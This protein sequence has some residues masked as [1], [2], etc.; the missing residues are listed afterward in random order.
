MPPT[1]AEAF[2][3]SEYAHAAK[4][5][6]HMRLKCAASL[7]ELLE[8]D[9]TLTTGERV[10]A[11]AKVQAY[12]PAEDVP[13]VVCWAVVHR[14]APG[15]ILTTPRVELGCVKKA[16]AEDLAAAIYTYER[17]YAERKKWLVDNYTVDKRT[18]DPA[19]IV[20][21]DLTGAEYVK[22]HEARF[23]AFR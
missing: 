21:E 15:G 19:W 6:L 9:T 17:A 22:L 5:P 8:S 12:L 7:L 11:S 10:R 4:L 3:P 2:M 23:G 14:Y 1:L 18:V 16:Q 13:D 20:R